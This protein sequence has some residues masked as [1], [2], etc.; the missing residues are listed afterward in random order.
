[1]K[2]RMRA[3][4]LRWGCHAPGYLGQLAGRAWEPGPLPLLTGS[5]RLAALGKVG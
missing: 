3:G 4:H 5:L 1:M 2:G